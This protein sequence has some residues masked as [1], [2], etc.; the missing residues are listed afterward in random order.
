[1]SYPFTFP[2][3]RLYLTEYCCGLILVLSNRQ[4]PPNTCATCDG[5]FLEARAPD[6][7]AE[8]EAESGRCSR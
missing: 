1:M 7:I 5:P 2:T 6:T 3:D 4:D 8:I